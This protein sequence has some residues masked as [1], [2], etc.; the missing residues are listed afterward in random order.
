MI[1]NKKLRFICCSFETDKPIKT[2]AGE[3]NTSEFSVEISEN[4]TYELELTYFEVLN[5]SLKD[6][7]E[8]LWEFAQIRIKWETIKYYYKD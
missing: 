6:F 3:S 8:E 4:N 5:N 1:E 7:A 2:A